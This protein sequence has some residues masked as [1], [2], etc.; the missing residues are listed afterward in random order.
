MVFSLLLYS[1]KGLGAYVI[2]FGSWFGA[3][4]SGTFVLVPLFCELFSASCMSLSLTIF[5]VKKKKKK[6]G[7]LDWDV[8]I[9]RKREN[10]GDTSDFC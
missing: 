6:T 8:G 4:V 10:R 1:S 2:A 9:G 5:T 3:P 7:K